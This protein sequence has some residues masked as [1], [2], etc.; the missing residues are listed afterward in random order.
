MSDI[1][2]TFITGTIVTKPSWFP[3]ANNKKALIF[4]IKSQESFR[5]ADG[6]MA[7][8]SNYLTIEVLGKNAEKYFQELQLNQ[9]YQI[10]G[11]LRVDE[12][13]GTDKVRIRAFR[14]EEVFNGD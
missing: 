14:I 1:N 9:R 4:N 8:H 6:R 7:A 11:Y 13:K 12:I 3:L 10:A 5:L 2:F